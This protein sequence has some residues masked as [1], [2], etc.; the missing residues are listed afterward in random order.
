M[1]CVAEVSGNRSILGH[2]VPILTLAHPFTPGQ[3]SAPNAIDPSAPRQGSGSV[4][5]WGMR[6]RPLGSPLPMTMVPDLG[7]GVDIYDPVT[8]TIDANRA[9]KVAAWFIDSDYD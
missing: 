6:V 2:G 3:C 7:E 8:N 5:A 4:L 1:K 9:D